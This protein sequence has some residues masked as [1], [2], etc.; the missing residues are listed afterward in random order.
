MG[1]SS[2]PAN[3]KLRKEIVFTLVVKL[4]FLYLLWFLFFQEP[5]QPLPA[6]QQFE[7]Y[8]FGDPV[9]P[10]SRVNNNLLLNKEP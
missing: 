6:H 7:N 5:D 3:S 9:P 1:K 10:D 8:V 4:L 2:L